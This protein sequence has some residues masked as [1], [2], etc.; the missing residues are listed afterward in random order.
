MK[1]PSLSTENFHS[2]G[3]RHAESLSP[4]EANIWF[5]RNL[6]KSADSFH[7]RNSI[8]AFIVQK[9]ENISATNGCIVLPFCMFGG[10]GGPKIVLF[11]WNLNL[12][13]REKR[14]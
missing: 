11:D 4:S 9:S 10:V 2:V 13:V 6:R 12:F 1:I 14:E 7:K 5:F 8:P 3:V